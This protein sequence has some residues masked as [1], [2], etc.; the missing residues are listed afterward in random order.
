M[1]NRH[2]TILT[3]VL[4]LY[5]VSL[6]DKE[7]LAVPP[8]NQPT[9]VEQ[10]STD[11]KETSY[12]LGPGDRLRL[13]ILDA[14]DYSGEYSVLV[15]GTITFPLVGTIKAQDLTVAE[16]TEILTKRFSRYFKRPI[17]SVSLISTRPLKINISGEVNN[18]GTY[19]LPVIQGQKFPF[20][21]DM[22]KQAGGVTTTADATTVKILR[23]YQGKNQIYNLNLISLLQTGDRSQDISLR[24]GD[25]VFVPT[26][27]VVDQ[28]EV[29][30]LSDANFGIQTSRGVTVAVVGEITRPGTYRLGDST[31]GT[32]AGTDTINAVRRSEFPRVS[33]ALQKA[34]GTKPL[35]D[36]RNVE[37]QR[38]TRSGEV[39]VI[40]V[41]LWALIQSGNVDQDVIL[42]DG[43][44]IT[45][46]TAQ[47]INPKESESLAS[48]NFAPDRIR[49][50]IVGEVVRPGPVEIPPNTPLNQAIL[51][52]G[53]F[54][55][56]R[57]EQTFVQL[58]RLNPNGTVSQRDIQVNLAGG[59]NEEHNPILL[60]SDV[61]IV[62]RNGLTQATDIVGTIFAPFSPLL[63]VLGT[64][65]VFR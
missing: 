21:T 26:K 39:Q 5:S 62:S 28:K 55:Q 31:A 1:L 24:D 57:A 43:D 58:I 54:D 53:G 46:P 22:I 20:L 10:T 48:A 52:A 38:V 36:V 4:V 19:T 49:V 44:T 60:T 47:K 50:N 40:P 27:K 59:I 41:D 15:D 35:A 25:I 63:G 11:F 30:E 12:T 3:S 23:T 18:P 14:K 32:P 61:V 13:D 56:R 16:L 6:I 64:F 9:I 7:A 37:I 34:G 33:A 17:L 42:Q 2:L 45:I 29:R 8:G 65:N 51:A